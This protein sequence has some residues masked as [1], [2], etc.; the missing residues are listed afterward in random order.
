MVSTRIALSIL[1]FSFSQA[2]AFA[3]PEKY[4]PSEKTRLASVKSLDGRIKVYAAA[5]ERI[6]KNLR[7]NIRNREFAAAPDT[8]AAWA[9]LLLESRQDIENNSKPRSKSQKLIRYE[10]HLRQAIGEIR[11]ARLRAPFEQKDDFDEFLEQA[12]NTR[13]K[14]IE[15]LFATTK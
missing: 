3:S 5:S 8:L 10:I 13:K 7:E 1:L 9:E 14:F 6:H 2:A 11:G 12:E 15:I 4:T